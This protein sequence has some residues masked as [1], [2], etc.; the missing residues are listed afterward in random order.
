[1]KSYINMVICSFC[2][3]DNLVLKIIAPKMKVE[4]GYFEKFL[5]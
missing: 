3:N 2:I 4:G 1:M 5:L